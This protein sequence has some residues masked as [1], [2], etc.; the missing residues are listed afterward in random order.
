MLCSLSR[1]DLA[2]SVSSTRKM[3]FPFV[4]F[5]Y[6]QLNNAVLAPPTCKL[7]VG[8]GANR[9]RTV[10]S[11]GGILISTSSGCATEEDAD[12]LLTYRTFERRFRNNAQWYPT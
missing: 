10:P 3:N 9:T 4:F 1:V 5:A 12:V 7:P 6:N 11:F 2:V 8:D